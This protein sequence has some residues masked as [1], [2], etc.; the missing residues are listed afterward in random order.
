MVYKHAYLDT[1]LLLHSVFMLSVV[2]MVLKG[3]VGC[4]VL[5]SHGIYI[6]DYGKS[7]QNHGIVFF[8]FLWE[9]RL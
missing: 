1:S 2:K 6:V 5:N 4:H 9:P 3:E 8:E 7:W